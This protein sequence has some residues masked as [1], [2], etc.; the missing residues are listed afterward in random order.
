MR[1]YIW[2]LG[3]EGFMWV[4]QYLMWKSWQIQ[5]L[6]VLAI[7]HVIDKNNKNIKKKKPNKQ[8]EKAHSFDR[9][10]IL[11]KNLSLF[12]KKSFKIKALACCWPFLSVFTL[13]STWCL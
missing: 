5:Y 2:I 12:I 8:R 10:N 11:P 6:L 13:M 4:K 7:L 1:I 9:R 3:L